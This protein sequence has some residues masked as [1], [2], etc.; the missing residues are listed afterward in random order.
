MG[1]NEIPQLPIT[2]LA[3]YNRRMEENRMTNQKTGDYIV[4]ATAA[5]LFIRAF[6]IRATGLAEE[7]RTIHQTTPVMTAAM[8]R[9]LAAGA[10][11][12]T[13]LKN[14]DDVLT[15]QI[16]CDGPAKGLTVTATGDGTIKGFPA[17]PDADLPL[18]PEDPAHPEDHKLDV[19]GALGEGT[20][21]VIMDLGLKEPYSGTVPLQ[22]GEIGDDLAYYYTASEQVP[23]AVGLGVMVDTDLSVRHAGGFIIQLMPD[24]PEDVIV[25]LEQNLSH[26]PSVT[27]LMDQG[28][29]PEEILGKIL[30]GLSME[31]T[32]TDPIRYYC[33]CSKDRVSRALATLQRK[34]L[35]EMIDD[36]EEIEVKC[37]FCNTAYRF[38]PENLQEILAR[39]AAERLAAAV[40]DEF[41]G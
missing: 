8:G 9:L 4:R 38:T 21:N 1:R 7:S 36:G 15:L 16:R 2:G 37:H 25:R 26:L 3:V 24:C 22:T 40:S 11:M 41:N 18:K 31:I 12:G 28:A 5:D 10:M 14:P 23:S 19:G 20:L 13:M 39:R 33:N 6:A 34:D 27:A 29:G 17:N 35:Q 32:E 30:E